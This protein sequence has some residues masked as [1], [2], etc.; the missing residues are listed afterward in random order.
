MKNK[1]LLAIFILLGLML[2]G[3]TYYFG[4][5]KYTDKTNSLK[6]ENR[7]LK[8]T[9]DAYELVYVRKEEFET[10]AD[11]FRKDSDRIMDNFVYGVSREDE[12]MY[13]T[14]LE[15]SQNGEDYVITVE[16]PITEAVVESTYDLAIEA[17]KEAFKEL[18]IYPVE[19]VKGK[20]TTSARVRSTTDTSK[21]DN[22]ITVLQKNTEVDILAYTYTAKKVKWYVISF[23]NKDGSEV[24]GLIRND[25]VKPVAEVVDYVIPTPTPE[26]LEKLTT[27]ENGETLTKTIEIPEEVSNGALKIN[28]MNMSD[29]G[30][31]DYTPTVTQDPAFSSGLIPV[32]TVGDDGIVMKTY[33]VNYTGSASYKA[34]K[35]MIAY[36]NAVGGKKNITSVVLSFNRKN[37]LLT[38]NIATDFFALEGTN[39][40]YNPLTIP[41]VDTSLENIFGTIEFTEQDL[42][43]YI[44]AQKKLTEDSMK[45]AATN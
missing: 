29:A 25:L 2:L 10:A 17:I 13:L 41:V 3:A 45:E 27:D 1:N 8:A 21:K 34:F 35:D 23:K 6:S 4:F 5:L 28:Y 16:V 31:V 26:E 19:T 42:L 12:I 9:A 39:R 18:D 33:T 43:D 14:N 30:S 38:V 20:I 44:E 37:G 36:I 24:A 32:P 7:R 22:V 11:D 15:D 40:A